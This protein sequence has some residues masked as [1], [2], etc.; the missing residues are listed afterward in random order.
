MNILQATKS[1]EGW[2]RTCT[3]LVESQIRDKHA[4]MKK[5][6]YAFFRGTFYRWAQLWSKVCA[7]STSAPE[8][9]AV[10]DLHIDSFGTWRDIEGR[11]A[12]GVDDFDESYPLSYT[13]DLVRL[14]ASV[15]IAIDSETLTIAFKE[16][17]D[18]IL[19]GYRDTLKD[20]G[21]PFVLA[22]QKRNLVRLGI[23]EIVPPEDFWQKLNQRPGDRL[24]I[25][26]VAKE[27]LEAELQGSRLPSR[28]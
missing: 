27:A 12:W 22:E 23:K 19:N 7:D 1:Y 24:A 20:E 25:P 4:R 14:A 15:K 17:C 9:L 26:R 2:M 18:L 11:L 3:T 13:N 21:C 16:A 5:D 6:L 10:G 8:I 28:S